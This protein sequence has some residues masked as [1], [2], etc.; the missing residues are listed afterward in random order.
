MRRLSIILFIILSTSHF[1]V[2]QDTIPPVSPFLLNVSVDPNTGFTHIFWRQ[3]PSDDVAAYI[4]FHSVMGSWVLIDTVWNISK[5][6]YLWSSGNGKF[7]QESYV[8]SA[9]DNTLEN[10]SPLTEQHSTIFLQSE[11]D[12]CKNNL[13]LQWTYYEGWGDS[14]LNYTVFR[15]INTGPYEKIATLSSDTNFY[16]DSDILSDSTYCYYIEANH[17]NG[18]QATSYRACSQVTM[19]SP[20]A[21]LHASGT[22]ILDDLIIKVIFDVDPATELNKYYLLRSTQ[23]EGFYDTLKYLE[24]SPDTPLEITDTLPEQGIYYYKLAALNHCAKVV[25]LSNV[26]SLMFLKITNQNFLNELTWNAYKDWP[27]GV[28][29]YYIY[30]QIGQSPSTLIATLDPTD[31]NYTDHIETLINQVGIGDFCYRIEAKEGNNPHGMGVSKSNLACVEPRILLFMP[32]A[33]TPNGDGQNDQ[34]IPYLTFIPVEYVFIIRNRL[35]N[36]LFQSNDYQIAWD[37][38]FHGHFVTEGVYIYYVEAKAPDGKI[39][40]KNG[41]V[42]VIYPKK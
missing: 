15:K 22:E 25:G 41:H 24:S 34:F 5:T 27:A 38:Q 14:L 20:P 11:F 7:R 31:T 19:P 18:L 37:G 8:I 21:W 35:G 26:A 42:T 23:I 13:K 10:E 6:D 3:S 28:S 39:L 40:R 2:A 16:D 32:N 4:I 9:I 29:N 1:S 12:S 36:I 17:K 33:F 30:R